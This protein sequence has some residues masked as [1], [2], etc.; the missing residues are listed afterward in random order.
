MIPYPLAAQETGLPAKK[1][2]PSATIRVCRHPSCP[3]C[4]IAET[5]NFRILWC[6][7]EDDVRDLAQMC[8]RLSTQAKA[9]W[10]N[11]ANAA[12]WAPQ[13]DIVVH[14]TTA[15]YVTCMGPQSTDFGLC[16]PSAS[17]RV[18]L[19]CDALICAPNRSI[20]GLRACRT[21]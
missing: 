16:H 10:L 13:C 17:I 21:N 18:M 1:S 20:G 14:S 12:V 5:A 15:D 7:A 6:A 9:A 8:E 11:A 19:S 3:S 4:L 2:S